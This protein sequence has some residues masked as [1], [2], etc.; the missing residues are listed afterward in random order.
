MG[1]EG[2]ACDLQAYL[3]YKWDGSYKQGSSPSLLNSCFKGVGHLCW[4]ISAPIPPH[5]LQCSNMY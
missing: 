5:H 1:S 2:A 4:T 3:I